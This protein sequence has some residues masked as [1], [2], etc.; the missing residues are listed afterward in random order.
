[1]KSPKETIAFVNYVL[2]FYGKGGIYEFDC[3]NSTV[4]KA[5]LE[6]RDLCDYPFT[7][8]EWG[9]GDSIDRERVR[10]MLE[11]DGF[12]EIGAWNGNKD[13]KIKNL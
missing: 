8:C 12:V 11:T 2:D 9:G 1:M 5:C 13:R 7:N 10:A 4:T 6:Y 3:S